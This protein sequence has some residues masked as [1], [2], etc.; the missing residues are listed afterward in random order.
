MAL[1]GW[2]ILT[3]ISLGMAFLVMH[4]F[5]DPERIVLH[6]QGQVLS[7]ADGKVIAIDKARDP[8][9]GEQRQ[10]ISIFM[11]VF[12]V[13][14]N[15]SPVT[16]SIS[17]QHYWPGRFF[18][19]SLDKSSQDNERNGI[20]ITDT[21]GDQWAVVQI[22]G[23]IARRILCWAEEGD[24]V[25]QGERIGLIKFGSR[26]DLYLPQ[27]YEIT[28]GLGQKVCAGMDVLAQSDSHV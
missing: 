1:L 4:F 6:R 9:I 7:P 27:G 22:A 14:I 13:H 11:N 24:C 20:Q 23:L 2:G 21:H 15:R 5:R 10:R 26:V 25:R 17:Q 3:L 8:F 19:A 28:V 16:G 18:N 12:N